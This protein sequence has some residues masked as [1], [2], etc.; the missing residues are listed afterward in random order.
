MDVRDLALAHVRAIEVPQAAGQRFFVTA[1]YFANKEIADI[2]RDNYPDLASSL[3]PKDYPSDMPEG[4]YK[5]DN[6]RSKKI[7][8]LHYR[9]LKD[10]IVD[11]VKSLQAVGV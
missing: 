11:L 4:I 5:I 7:L 3:P 1:G 10:S 8:G 6:S 2:V 9:P